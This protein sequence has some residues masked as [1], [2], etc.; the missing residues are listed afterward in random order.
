MMVVTGC[1]SVQ[2]RGQISAGRPSLATGWTSHVRCGEN[3]VGLALMRRA[4]VV[5]MVMLV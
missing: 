4:V 2:Q 5:V 3:A 1:A